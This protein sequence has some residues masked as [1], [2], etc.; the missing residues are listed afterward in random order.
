MIV[1]LRWLGVIPAAF[2]GFY[3]AL[4]IGIYAD[5]RLFDL[6]P[7]DLVV[8]GQ[9]TAAWYPMAER[10]VMCFGAALAALLVVLFSALMAPS[11]RTIISWA[12]FAV[13][14]TVAI[15]GA[16]SSSSYA[17]L[18]AALFAGLVATQVIRRFPMRSPS[19]GP[20]AGV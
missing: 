16:V 4:I 19:R 13:G 12:A 17:E 2:A 15:Y 8:S 3:S 7:P 5:G 18:A 1:W 14:A 9:C 20:S 11:H 10:G 6:C